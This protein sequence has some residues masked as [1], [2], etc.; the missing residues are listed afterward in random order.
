MSVRVINLVRLL[1]S[2][3]LYGHMRLLLLPLSSRARMPFGSDRSNDYTHTTELQKLSGT[4]LLSELVWLKY[5]MMPPTYWPQLRGA[6]LGS[7]C[8]SRL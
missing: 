3:E 8:K 4:H 6:R 5:W 1:L 7:L 2:P